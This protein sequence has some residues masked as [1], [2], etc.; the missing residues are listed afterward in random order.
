MYLALIDVFEFETYLN[1]EWRGF[2][3][4]TKDMMLYSERPNGN[5]PA[6]NNDLLTCAVQ[7]H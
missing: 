7:H 4:V 3:M 6:N 5:N 2:V 1:N